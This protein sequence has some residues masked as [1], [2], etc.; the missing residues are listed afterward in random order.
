MSL[1]L[2]HHSHQH[3]SS[4]PSPAPSSS[5]QRHHPYASSASSARSRSYTSVSDLSGVSDSDQGELGFDLDNERDNCVSSVG[6]VG[7]H[8]D[9][10]F[11]RNAFPLV[12]ASTS[13]APPTGKPKVSH[14]R[15]TPEGHVKRPPNAFI[16]FRSHC[17]APTADPEQLHAPGTPTAQQLQDLG[18][19]DHRHI[20]RIVSHLWKSLSADEK[21]YW[22]VKAKARKT[23]HQRLHP[24]YRY[25]PV[26]RNKDEVKRRRK[27]DEEQRMKE[28]Q[29]CEDVARALLD[30]PLRTASEERREREGVASGG[31]KAGKEGGVQ[32][33]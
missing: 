10:S 21:S 32:D 28:E 9:F 2:M 5:Y 1:P 17:C 22:E 12:S 27:G 30:Q 19:T 33:Q 16:L 25:K 14:A 3:P 7:P 8:P 15:K 29:G 6:S 20:S 4:A 26:Y 11:G 24:D 23:E 31:E 13:A 18:I